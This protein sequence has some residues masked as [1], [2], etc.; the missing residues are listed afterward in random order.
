[1]SELV[2][3]G[4]AKYLIG[5]DW[6]SFDEPLSRKDLFEMVAQ[7]AETYIR[8]HWYQ[9]GSRYVLAL[10]SLMATGKQIGKN[11]GLLAE[12]LSVRATQV[13]CAYML[14][15][16][17]GRFGFCVIDSNR[18][19][20]PGSD[21]LV[22]D[23][24]KIYES[25]SAYAGLIDS[26]SVNQ[27]DL[28]G[29]GS[30]L[31]KTAIEKHKIARVSLKPLPIAQIAYTGL[32]VATLAAIG[33]G[34]YKWYSVNRVP[35]HTITT[36]LPAWHPGQGLQ[37]K[38]E[39]KVVVAKAEPLD[40]VTM[41]PLCA[42]VIMSAPASVGGFFVHS[43]NCVPDVNSSLRVTVSYD[44][45][46]GND[47]QHAMSLM[48]GGHWSV[49]MQGDKLVLFQIL[50]TVTK[51]PASENIDAGL[52]LQ[53]Y[54]A[55][56]GK[57]A[58]VSQGT[59]S[60]D[61]Q[62]AWTLS[63]VIAPWLLPNRHVLDGLRVTALTGEFDNAQWRLEIAGDNS[64]EKTTL[65]AVQNASIPVISPAAR[66]LSNLSAAPKNSAQGWNAISKTN[67]SVMGSGHYGN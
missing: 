65:S 36:N 43:V 2:S 9:T 32:A 41:L 7:S 48:S 64:S 21:I 1:M 44:N 55:G 24:A 62:S 5:L 40:V 30:L 52:V 50:R 42:D 26:D 17:D 12:M 13:P 66:A 63:S 59:S 58:Q 47:A 14:D 54:V 6:Q 25:L 49:Q 11:S 61:Q 4:K 33:F 22:D 29:I 35:L 38:A 56:L 51:R 31:S 34:A 23:M 67:S 27:L 15:Y 39:D 53:R 46:F 57:L 3:I 28:D 19:V 45:S 37:A 60:D 16:G 8:A 20:L 18:M 10:E